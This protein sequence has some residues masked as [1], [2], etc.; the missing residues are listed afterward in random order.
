MAV[1]VGDHD[2]LRSSPAPVVSVQRVP[3]CQATSELGTGLWLLLP[4]ATEPHTIVSF[5]PHDACVASVS[6]AERRRPPVQLSWVVSVDGT[7]QMLRAALSFA[8]VAWR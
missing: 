8:Q 4:P 1:P 2:G 5:G 3:S 6:V 7:V